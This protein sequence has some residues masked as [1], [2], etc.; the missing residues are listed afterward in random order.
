MSHNS[1]GEEFSESSVDSP[2]KVTFD[3]KEE[4]QVVRRLDYQIVPLMTMFY[5]LSFLACVEFFALY[6]ISREDV[7]PCKHR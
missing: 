4:K 3:A 5:L 2:D 7:G 1:S 6:S